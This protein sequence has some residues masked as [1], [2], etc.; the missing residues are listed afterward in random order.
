MAT[1]KIPDL[2][3]QLEILFRTLEAAIHDLREAKLDNDLACVALAAGQVSSITSKIDILA[4]RLHGEL[5][6]QPEN[7]V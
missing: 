7:G 3:A 4:Q 5:K 1:S 2:K 6:S